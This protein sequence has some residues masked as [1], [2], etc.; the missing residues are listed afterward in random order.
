M[1]WRVKRRV[2]KERERE[3][4]TLGD[5]FPVSSAHTFA[6]KSNVINT[7]AHTH[8]RTVALATIKISIRLIYLFFVST[9]LI[10][11]FSSNFIQFC[12]WLLYR[13]WWYNNNKMII[14]SIHTTISFVCFCFRL[15]CVLLFSPSIS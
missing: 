14:Y 2:G 4:E 8:A 3:K 7:Q 11:Y 9:K 5:I 1:I 12:V 15:F 10:C 6:A 13:C